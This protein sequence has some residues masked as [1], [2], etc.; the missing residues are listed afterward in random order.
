MGFGEKF[1]K[2]WKDLFGPVP[3]KRDEFSEEAEEERRIE[4]EKRADAERMKEREKMLELGMT[5]EE[6]DAYDPEKCAVMPSS[7]KL[8]VMI[9][10]DTHGRLQNLKKALDVEKPIDVLLHCGDVTGDENI[11]R[12]MA[13]C[14]VRI[15][16]GNMDFGSGCPERDIFSIGSHK[17][18]LC[19]GHRMSVNS[20]N[21]ML[22]S[23]AR[24]LGA[25][26]AFYGHTHKP[27]ISMNN[28]VRIV[29][30]GSIS[31]P[32][33]LERKYTYVIMEVDADSSKMPEFTLKEVEDPEPYRFS[34]S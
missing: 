17:F 13:G 23:H 12:R 8:K 9:V 5:E 34:W 24:A 7:G 16:S 19:H 10:S 18:L 27:E 33:Q 14:H 11:I 31:Q 22:A 25:E 15:V 21:E 6:I 29:N 3:E 4:K 30:P 20:G 28:G 1:N 2:I 32:R 26:A